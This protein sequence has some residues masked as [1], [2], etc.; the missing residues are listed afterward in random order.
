MSKYINMKDLGK[1]VVHK[2][3]ATAWSYSPAQPKLKRL[4]FVT[5]QP[6]EAGWVDGLGYYDDIYT[7][8]KVLEENPNLFYDGTKIVEKPCVVLHFLHLNKMIQYFETVEE[9][10]SYA[11]NL[12]GNNVF[13]KSV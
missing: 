13:F 1:V 10:E 2:T 7:L 11:T 3:G 4:W 9:A 6:R 5:Q 8:E 12:V